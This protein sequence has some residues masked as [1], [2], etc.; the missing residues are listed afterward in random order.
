MDTHALLWLTESS[1]KLSSIANTV[2]SDLSNRAFYSVVS[3]WEIAIKVGLKKLHLQRPIEV[4]FPEIEKRAPDLRL[5][6]LTPHLLEY[7]RL[8]FYHRDPFD[9]MIVAQALS[10]NLSVISSDPALDAYGIRRIW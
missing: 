8:P 5:P 1:P 6:L 4:M 3:L 9:R 2:V 7:T 10:E